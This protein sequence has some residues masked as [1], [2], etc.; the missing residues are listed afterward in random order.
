M[1][2]QCCNEELIFVNHIEPDGD[3]G[4]YEPYYECPNKCSYPEVPSE[5]LTGGEIMD[6]LNESVG[7]MVPKLER[8]AKSLR[9]EGI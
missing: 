1:K 3:M 6:R 4:S 5:D 9:G 8:I 7:A 2:C